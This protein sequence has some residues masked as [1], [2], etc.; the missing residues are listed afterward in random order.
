MYALVLF[1]ILAWNQIAE[2]DETGPFNNREE[3]Q[4]AMYIGA[5]LLEQKD[6]QTNYFF[7]CRK[8]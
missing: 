1:Q 3:C 4:L 8:I 6:P 7:L 2:V 5:K